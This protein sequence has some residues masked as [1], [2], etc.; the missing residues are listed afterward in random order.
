[1]KLTIN[2]G[3]KNPIKVGA[4]QEFFVDAEVNGVEVESGISEQPKSLEETFCGARTRAEACRGEAD[5]GIGIE[6]GVMP[7]NIDKLEWLNIVTCSI[8]DGEKHCLGMG[9]GFIVPPMFMAI[10]LTDNVDLSEAA[11]KAGFTQKKRIGYEEGI[12]DPLTDGKINRKEYIKQAITMAL[13][14]F[15]HPEH[16]FIEKP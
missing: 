6:S 1:M 15:G 10:A 13:A 9:S 8:W 4:V 14:P 5:F 16:Y 11:F 12:I 2:V 7:L 3:S